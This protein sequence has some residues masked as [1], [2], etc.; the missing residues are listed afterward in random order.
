MMG[1]IFLKFL[2]SYRPV[3]LYNL[4]EEKNNAAFGSS[5]EHKRV[6]K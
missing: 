2:E 5:F 4:L 6:I 3:A 1:I